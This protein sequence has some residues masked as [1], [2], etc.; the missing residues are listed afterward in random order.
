MTSVAHL[1]IL[2]RPAA[3]MIRVQQE[4]FFSGWVNSSTEVGQK[5]D[6]G[7]QRTRPPE[8]TTC[9]LVALFPVGQLQWADASRQFFQERSRAWLLSQLIFARSGDPCALTAPIL[10]PG[11]VQRA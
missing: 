11:V 1:R 6:Q 10:N 4:Y 3:P 9:W 8:S 5:A 2:F 7:L